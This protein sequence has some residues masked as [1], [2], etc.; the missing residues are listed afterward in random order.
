MFAVAGIRQSFAMLL[1]KSAD[2]VDKFDSPSC[3]QRVF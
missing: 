1:F 3:L 2:R